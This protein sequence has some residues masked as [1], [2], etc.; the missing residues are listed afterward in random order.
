L[1]YSKANDKR[2]TQLEFPEARKFATAM[3]GL[4]LDEVQWEENYYGAQGKRPSLRQAFPLNKDLCNKLADLLYNVIKSA[5]TNHSSGAFALPETCVPQVIVTTEPLSNNDSGTFDPTSWTLSVSGLAISSLFEARSKD[6]ENVGVT[7]AVAKLTDFVDTIYHETRH[8]QQWFWMFAM[9][10]QQTANFGDTPDIGRLPAAVAGSAA[11]RH[12]VKIAST[13]KIPDDNLAL[14]GIKRMAAGIYLF[15][16]DKYRLVNAHPTYISDHGSFESEYANARQQ[17]KKLLSH[18]GAGGMPIDVDRMLTDGIGQGYM[19]R[20]WEDDAFFCGE[21]AGIYWTGHEPQN[22]ADNQCSRKY[23]LS[24]NA[25]R[26]SE[27]ASELPAE[28]P[29]LDNGAK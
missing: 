6:V 12:A 28:Q 7:G 18:A 26:L 22:I 21:L 5:L 9:L 2:P 11:A 24:Y 4:L 8:C 15:V 14:T 25:G 16:L 17:A 1:R 19:S 23:A 13:Q 20:P 27:L 3:R 10:Q 29:S